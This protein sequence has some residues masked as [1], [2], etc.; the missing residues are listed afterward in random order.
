[1]DLVE[2]EKPELLSPNDAFIEKT[3]ASVSINFHAEMS[4]IKEPAS[5]LQTVIKENALYKDTPHK[6]PQPKQGQQSA[7]K[8]ASGARAK[9]ADFNLK[10]AHD[11]RYLYG[12]NTTQLSG[13]SQL[14]KMFPAIQL[15]DYKTPQKGGIELSG[16]KAQH[17][18][19]PELDMV[20]ALFK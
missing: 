7:S 20:R 11:S 5:D 8:L 10:A 2:Q 15:P 17:L 16:V 1:M 14:A 19:R 3:P 6:S 13:V 12:V 4:R 9:S 18:S